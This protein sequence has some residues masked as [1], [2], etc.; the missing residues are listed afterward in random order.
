MT[1]KVAH[2]GHSY[3]FSPPPVIK[4]GHLIYTPPPASPS[5]RSPK[6]GPGSPGF[7]HGI[8]LIAEDLRHK[9]EISQNR[10]IV[11]AAVVFAGV[12][13]VIIIIIARVWRTEA[14]ADRQPVVVTSSGY[15]SSQPLV[16]T[17]TPPSSSTNPF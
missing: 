6:M 5:P 12:V 13:L 3:V 8:P 4:D 9:Q 14:L 2:T 10:L 11:T 1:S 17:S 15:Y 16:H 7:F